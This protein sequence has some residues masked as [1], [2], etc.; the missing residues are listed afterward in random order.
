M[1]RRWHVLKLP[2][3]QPSL[4]RFV[5][6]YNPERTVF[7]GAV[8]SDMQRFFGA[9][10]VLIAVISVVLSVGLFNNLM[11]AAILLLPLLFLLALDVSRPTNIEYSPDGFRIHWL[12]NLFL[13]VGPWIKW[14]NVLAV[15]YTQANLP[16][17]KKA[18]CFEITIDMSAEHDF[19]FEVMSTSIT[20]RVEDKKLTLRLLEC[21]FFNESD[22]Q[23]FVSALKKFVPSE[24][25]SLDLLVCENFGEVPSYTAIWLDSLQGV[26]DAG[27]TTLPNGTLLADG[28]YKVLSRLGSGGQ[29]VVYDAIAMSAENASD[30]AC[31]LKEFVLPIRGGS[32]IK[33]RAVENVQRE[34]NLLK[35]FSNKNIVEFRDIFTEGPRAYLVMERIF[36]MSLRRFVEKNGALL[37]PQT[38]QRAIEMCELLAFLHSC[39]PPIIHRDF[40]PENLMLTD[41]GQLKLIDFNVAYRLESTSTRTVV[42]KHAYV[43][44]EQF[45]GKPT[46]QSDIY[47]L[48]ATLFFLLTGQDPEPISKSDPRELCP[49]I[50]A[51]FSEMVMKA[52]EPDAECRYLCAAALKDDL[53]EI[54]GLDRY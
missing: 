52:T 10:I 54:C 44:P 5:L 8:A 14:D 36:G 29:A 39:E 32:D 45:R 47:A 33:R 53:M 1:D 50:S 38:I 19:M 31:V 48:G 3:S 9:F 41:E 15:K 34:A 30:E 25:S 24:R 23:S 6:H 16:G 46:I 20:S 7:T 26:R 17:I 49:L 18:D 27:D 21:G 37:E 4:G 22:R 11:L 43:P 2:S 40:T 42:G 28:K 51:E 35:S 12:H 13:H